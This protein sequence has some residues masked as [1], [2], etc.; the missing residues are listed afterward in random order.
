M[1]LLV[2]DD[3]ATVRDLVNQQLNA[4]GL[5]EVIFAR[6]GYEALEQFRRHR[7]EL[8]LLD[9]TMPEMD[10]LTCLSQIKAIAPQTQ[11]AVISALTD[12]ET[13]IEAVER[14]ASEFLYKPFTGDEL[15][16]AIEQL[17]SLL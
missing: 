2:V 5:D 11:V 1:K 9:L 6:D 12:A 17:R 15:N 10:G 8:V 14:G 16:T 7:P 13:A 4:S 3:A